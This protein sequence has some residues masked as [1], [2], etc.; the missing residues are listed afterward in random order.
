MIGSEEFVDSS[1]ACGLVGRSVLAV[2]V[3]DLRDDDDDDVDALIGC[4][5]N[6]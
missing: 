3:V 5:S 4:A 1:C 2:L 6:G